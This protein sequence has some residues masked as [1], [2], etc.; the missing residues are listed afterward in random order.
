MKQHFTGIYK[1]YW[2]YW[3]KKWCIKGRQMVPILAI[4]KN[5]NSWKTVKDGTKEK[6]P[7]PQ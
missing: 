3:K 7:I 6:C 2:D 1:I 4:Q 5:D